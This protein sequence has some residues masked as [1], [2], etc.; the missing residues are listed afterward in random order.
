MDNGK[1][2]LRC[3]EAENIF[4]NGVDLL[5][6]AQLFSQKDMTKIQHGFNKEL[7]FLM[8][9]SCAIGIMT[10]QS[11]INRDGGEY[12]RIARTSIK[13]ILEP[14]IKYTN[15]LIDMCI[16]GDRNFSGFYDPKKEF[17]QIFLDSSIKLI[18]KTNMIVIEKIR[19]D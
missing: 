10:A 14:T 4:Q 12:D 9:G 19:M 5:Y 1:D 8:M 3:S 18:E 17:Y 16:Q 13:T 6:N 2:S 15:L 7:L 11:I